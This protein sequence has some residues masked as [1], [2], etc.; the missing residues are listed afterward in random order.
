ML[1]N[2]AP[3]T[4]HS[5][6]TTAKRPPRKGSLFKHYVSGGKV[7][8]ERNAG[9]TLAGFEPALRLIDHVNA[10]LATHNAAITVPVLE[11]AERIANFHV[12]TFPSLAPPSS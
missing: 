8:P 11:R 12:P 6:D 9:S 4:L 7:Q 2:S 3:Q 5:T 1:E 10:A